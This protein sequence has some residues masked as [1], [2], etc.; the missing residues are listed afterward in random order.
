M[1]LEVEVLLTILG[2]AATVI[3]GYVAM[4]KNNRADIEAK[5]SEFAIFSQKLDTV[6]DSFKD[7]KAEITLIHSDLERKGGQISENSQD[8]RFTKELASRTMQD[9]D[10]AH[11]DVAKLTERMVAAEASAK[12]AHLRIDALGTKRRRRFV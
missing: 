8:M 3:Y 2:V 12:S 11:T 9:V 10:R 6:I 4:T 1:H 7:L 5:S